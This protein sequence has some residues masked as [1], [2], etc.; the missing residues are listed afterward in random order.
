[1]F[2]FINV[3]IYSM[4]QVKNAKRKPTQKQSVIVIKKI[5]Q[6]IEWPLNCMSHMLRNLGNLKAFDMGIYVI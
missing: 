3:L 5:P 2:N 1:M 6:N 4:K